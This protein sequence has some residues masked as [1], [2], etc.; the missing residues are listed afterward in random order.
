[1]NDETPLFKMS[2]ENYAKRKI[3]EEE[4]FQNTEHGKKSFASW[5]SKH[6]QQNQIDDGLEIINV[7][8]SLLVYGCFIFST[9]HDPDCPVQIPTCGG[10]HSTPKLLLYSE[11][12]LM[13]LL[14]IDFLIFFVTSENRIEYVFS[15]EYGVVFY[16]PFFSILLMR[17]DI[18]KDQ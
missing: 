12:T 11:I 1:M 16:L 3:E 15:F 9:Y 14:S 5:I 7:F 4:D 2:Q 18:I 17:F 10:E 8:I 13:I 6:M